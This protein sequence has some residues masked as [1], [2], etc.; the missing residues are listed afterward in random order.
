M[1]LTYIPEVPVSNLGWDTE[2]PSCF[3]VFLQFLEAHSNVYLKLGHNY[4]FLFI[5]HF[6]TGMRRI[7]TFRSTMD[8]IYDG[9][10]I[11]L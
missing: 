2:E 1:C 4:L 7:T 11:R 6:I 9:G 5:S 3:V 10:P 8:R